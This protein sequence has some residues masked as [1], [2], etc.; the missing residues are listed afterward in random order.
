MAA[1]ANTMGIDR[2]ILRR[3]ALGVAVTIGTF[4]I[5]GTVSALW[6]NPLFIRMV[7]A[8]PAETTLLAAQSV[9]LGLFF[10][11]RPALCSANSAAAGGILGFLG[12][13][14]PICNQILVMIFGAEALLTYYEPVRIYVAAVGVLVTGLAVL[15]AL[16]RRL[17][18]ARS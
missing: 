10:A 8:G 4:V 6:D 13:A 16:R 3:V 1:Q 2:A 17:A 12:I 18:P 9:L 5:L 11:I 15:W 14:C 7:P